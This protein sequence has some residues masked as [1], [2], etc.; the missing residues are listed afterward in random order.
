MAEM[1]DLYMDADACPVKDEIYQVASRH[2]IY[3]LVVANARLS[4]PKDGGVEMVVV[5]AG[6]DAADDWIVDHVRARDL[7]VTADIP[8]ASRCLE[9]DALVISPTGH[10]FEADSIG[11][12]L[13]SREL[14]SH[15][16]ESG[17]L[18]GGPPP[19]SERDRSRFV[20]GLDQLVQVAL[21]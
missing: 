11:Q 12:S 7:V 3:V 9:K 15:L 4:V 1:I 20:S 18:F 6:F 16:R 2:G 14:N 19:L 17:T 21:R 8:L 5:S 10:R 13:A